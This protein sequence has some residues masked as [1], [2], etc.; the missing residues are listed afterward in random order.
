MFPSAALIVNRS[1]SIYSTSVSQGLE[2]AG[3]RPDIV[4]Q[5]PRRFRKRT[6]RIW[7]CGV[8]VAGFLLLNVLAYLQARG[9]THFAPADP[10]QPVPQRGLVAMI[11]GEPVPKPTCQET[12][13]SADL[14][15][16]T[17]RIPG[18][19][20]S[21]L[22]V[23]RIPSERPKGTVISFHGHAACKGQLIPAASEFHKLG[24]ECWLVDFHGSG[25]SSG[26][27]TTIGWDEAEDV[28]SAFR[29]AQKRSM[30]TPIILHGGSMGAAAI[31]K[32]VAELGVAPD[33]LIL[34]CPY[35]SLL[36]TVKN[37]IRNHHGPSFPVAHLMLFWGGW[38]NGFDPFSMNPVEYA[39]KVTMPTLLMQG[40]RD[41]T[42]S[43]EESKAILTNLGSRGRFHVL[44]GVG[45]VPFVEVRR[46]EWVETVESFLKE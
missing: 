32:A 41:E 33:R 44:S 42:I 35:D 6:F 21:E 45:H 5:P 31:L 16:A 27:T 25:G 29:H 24:Y 4:Q 39:K 22:E 28:A 38:Q 12:P 19:R 11:L 17:F 7:A 23:W 15:F 14:A 37:R 34:E 3:L 10:R 46:D 20:S 8:M 1:P 43:L 9:L 13:A 18:A 40:D 26:N 2:P 30:G 36:T